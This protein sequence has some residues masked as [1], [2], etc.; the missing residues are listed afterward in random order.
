VARWSRSGLL[1]PSLL[2][3]V[4]A[5][6]DE[7]DQPQRKPQRR[8]RSVKRGLEVASVAALMQTRSSV[9][10]AIG[11]ASVRERPACHGLIGDAWTR[12][13]ARSRRNRCA[14]R[15]PAQRS[16]ASS[17]RAGRPGVSRPATRCP[18]WL[19]ARGARAR[20]RA[21]SS[22]GGP[23]MARVTR[24]AGLV[25]V[26]DQ[27]VPADP[28]EALELDRFER[29]RDPTHHSARWPTPTSATASRRTS[30]AACAPT[31]CSRLPTSSAASTWPPA[32]ARNASAPGGWLRA[33]RSRLPS[34]G[35]CYGAD[36][37]RRLTV[38][39]TGGVSRTA[40]S[41]PASTASIASRR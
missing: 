4:G 26:V 25:L 3:A 32:R 17:G 22:S 10:R 37:G 35:T 31:T 40:G 8:V 34:A 36:Y 6:A 27:I 33:P 7:F 16:P 11:S 20:C 12:P 38:Q 24:P 13:P 21:V 9:A 28:L 23:R 5:L 30:S 14:G 41:C 2:R 39:P 15:C 29:A 19:G 1:R 18:E